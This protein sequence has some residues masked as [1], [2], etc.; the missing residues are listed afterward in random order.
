MFGASLQALL[1]QSRHFIT[2]C[3]PRPEATL[4]RTSSL[5]QYLETFVWLFFCVRIFVFLL[6][7][8]LFVPKD[9]HY[10]LRSLNEIAEKTQNPHHAPTAK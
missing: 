4:S 10:S 7:G 3:L 2:I 1:D 9:H 8:I 6:G 5:L